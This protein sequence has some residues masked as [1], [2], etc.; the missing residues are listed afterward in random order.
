M[1]GT[2]CSTTCARSSE[3][4]SCGRPGWRERWSSASAAGIGYV[5]HTA[6]EVTLYLE[7]SL[8][9]RVLEPDAAVA[10]R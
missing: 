8:S 10:L 7:E 5:S 2:S 1:V 6:E 4:L 3:A 9:F